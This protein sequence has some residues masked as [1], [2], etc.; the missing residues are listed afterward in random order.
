[1]CLSGVQSG[2]GGG[3]GGRALIRNGAVNRKIGNPPSESQ[4]ESVCYLCTTVL[5]LVLPPGII[6]V[7]AVVRM[8]YIIDVNLITNDI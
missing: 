3:K 5:F 8:L 6:H 1:M 2:G 7:Y 4:A